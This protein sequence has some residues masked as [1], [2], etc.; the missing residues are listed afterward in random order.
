MLLASHDRKAR[1]S[2][3]DAILA[4]EPKE[5]VA[6]Y[7][8]NV[9]WLDRASSCEA[10]KAVIKKIAEDG[11]PRALP[12]L[13]LLSKTPRKGCGVFNGSDCNECLRELLAKTIGQL[14]SKG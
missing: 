13:Q 2:A 9:A 11:D 5:E 3:A 14:N 4:H 6:L 1:K 7:A 10:K 12:A 8:R